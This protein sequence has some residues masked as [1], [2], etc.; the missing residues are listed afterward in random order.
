MNWFHE[1][2]KEGGAVTLRL[3]ARLDAYNLVAAC[4][5]QGEAMLIIDEVTASHNVSRR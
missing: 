1:T 2:K 4:L 3:E 5:V